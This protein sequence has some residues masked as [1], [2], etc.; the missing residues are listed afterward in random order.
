MYEYSCTVDRVV[1]GDTI[2]VVLDLG[3][4]SYIDQE[5]VYTELI[6]P[7]LELEIKM[8]KLEVNLLL[9]FYKKQ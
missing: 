4:I 9:L 6:P 3:L 5:Y 1:D 7:N 8:K 2:D